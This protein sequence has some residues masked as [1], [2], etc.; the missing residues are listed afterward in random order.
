MQEQI[1]V[2]DEM[3]A[4]RFDIF[5]FKYI[6]Y[7]LADTTKSSEKLA[8]LKDVIGKPYEESIKKFFNFYFNPYI[9]TGIAK[10][11]MAKQLLPVDSAIQSWDT[12]FE[13]VSQ[14]NTGSDMT[15]AI[16]QTWFSKYLL[17]EDVDL[18]KQIICK[19][20]DL[21]IGVSTTTVNKVWPNLIPVFSVMLAKKWNDWKDFLQGKHITITEKLDGNRCIAICKNGKVRL[22]TRGGRDYIGMTVIEN[23]L[24]MFDDIVF[25][26]E[27]KLA[28]NA[29]M[30]TNELY[31]LT[32]GALHSNV[33]DDKANIHFYVFDM[34]SY[35]EWVNQDCKTNYLDRRYAL[36]RL[37]TTTDLQHVQ[38]V[39]KYFAGMYD[40]VYVDN[41]LLEV[42]NQGKEGL[43]INLN[44]EKYVFERTNVLLKCKLF[45]SS[46]LL[47]SDVYEGTG[48]NT[49]K[50][51]GVHVLFEAEG[52]QYT[53]DVGSGFSKEERELFWQNKNLIIGKIIEVK[54]FEISQ[55][56]NGD[57]SLRF[58]V[59][60]QLRSEKT[61]I[62]MN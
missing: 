1:Q 46:D 41:L 12:L 43:M 4:P 36:E 51:G 27:L 14:N 15:V 21:S 19:S 9:I 37:L 17:P 53:C 13:Y 10:K 49:G 35:D 47:V 28:D 54:Y 61:E 3:S 45:N 2:N 50:L 24:S 55:N 59:F 52:K 16:C 56:A 44:D 6:C 39:R 34:L 58:P 31:R 33:S 48:E 57:Y 11:K 32:T 29:D 30:S 18:A 38:P 20:I 8:I 62:S 5:W 22:L 7:K 25:D 60:K 23:E 40:N 26:G 42:S